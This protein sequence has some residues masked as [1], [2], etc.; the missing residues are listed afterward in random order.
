[1][2]WRCKVLKHLK[3]IGSAWFDAHLAI[4]NQQERDWADSLGGKVE[5]LLADNLSQE[6]EHFIQVKDALLKKAYIKI[7]REQRW[8]FKKKGRLKAH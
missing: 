1:M 8:Q 6:N 3:A 4:E 5:L 7:R 2:K